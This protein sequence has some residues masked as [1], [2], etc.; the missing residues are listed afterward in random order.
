MKDLIK[1]FSMSKSEIRILAIKVLIAVFA[2][3]L[4]GFGISFNISAL[5]GSDPI[6]VFL[7]GMHNVTHLSLGFSTNIITY[8]LLAIVCLID[9]KYINVGTFVYTIPLG[10]F[11]NLGLKL[12]AWTAFP[13]NVL[14]WQILTVALGC[15]MLFVGLA[16][17]ISIDIGLDPWT[18]LVMMLK[19]KI[20]K[21]FRFSKCLVDAT[22]LVIGFIIGGKVGIATIF[23][24]VS[25]GPVIQKFASWFNV[26]LAG[27]L[28]SEIT[29]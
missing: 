20:K 24:A 29:E 21:S 28:K 14:G 16:I 1:K 7:D 22:V 18:A 23:A 27:S 15:L 2:V 17:F 8:T 9:R 10:L 26:L 11:V 12:Y 5:M 6:S 13:D 4:V 19:D 25:G 3:M